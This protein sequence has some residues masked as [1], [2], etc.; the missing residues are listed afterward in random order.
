[1]KADLWKEPVTYAAVGVTQADD[2]L[3]YPPRGYRAIE[4]T[5]RI[6]HG[7]ARFEYASL[8]ALTWGIQRNSGFRVRLTDTPP[9]V[10]EGTYAPV[11]FDAAGEPL[12]PAI[13]DHADEV[14]YGQDGTRILAPGDT[15][16]LRLPLGLRFSVR[17]VYVVNEAKRVGFAYG[18]LR[19]HPEE[20][21]EAWL[22]EH[23]DDGS[24]WITVRAFSRPA[25]LFWWCGYPIL[26][27]AQE[28]Y[29]RRYLRALAGP[30][31]A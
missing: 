25:N 13:N 9:Q 26:R 11:T 8:A 10:T 23:R 18:T 19:G 4:R 12:A 20:G 2:L 24:V 28:I 15:A 21:E 14:V 6:G 30:I 5:M 22:V 1:M 17:V 27:I 29:T 7:D 31:E 3:R 16:Q